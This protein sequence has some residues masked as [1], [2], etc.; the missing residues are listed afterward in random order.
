MRPVFVVPIAVALIIA[1]VFVCVWLNG[2]LKHSAI[3][4]EL[5]QLNTP[6]SLRE[7]PPQ[8]VSMD[9]RAIAVRSFEGVSE[10]KQSADV[11]KLE[12][13]LPWIQKERYQTY[14]AEIRRVSDDE[15]FIIPNLQAENDTSPIIRIRLPTDILNRGQYQVRLSGIDSGGAMGIT[16]E[17]AFMVD[18]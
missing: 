15:S 16:E 2:R 12:L 18:G 13:R 3:Q 1:A 7:V 17:Y 4:R 5:A 8:L 9:L 6:A 10:F 14:Q 11:Q